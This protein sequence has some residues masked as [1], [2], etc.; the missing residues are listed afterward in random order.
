MILR[1]D[2]GGDGVEVALHRLGHVRQR[3]V[4]KLRRA[5]LM[6]KGGKFEFG[7]MMKTALEIAVSLRLESTT[8]YETSLFPVQMQCRQATLMLQNSAGQ[9]SHACY[10]HPLEYTLTQT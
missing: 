6:R 9:N 8:I 7:V 2:D 5:D 3:Q 10:I 4:R 1:G